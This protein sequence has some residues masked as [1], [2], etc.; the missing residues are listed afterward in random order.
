MT[1]YI[2]LAGLAL[3]TAGCSAPNTEAD[4]LCSAQTG[5]ACTTISQV[6][7]RAPA[8][9]RVTESSTQPAQATRTTRS[10]VVAGAGDK[11]LPEQT[12][13]MFVTPYTTSNGIV[14]EET[15]VRFVV[16]SARWA[17]GPS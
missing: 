5:Q 7:G 17:N 10:S 15:T 13:R 12:G 11:R 6:D 8:A 16:R 3:A 4:F 1:R 14:T 2:C 9:R